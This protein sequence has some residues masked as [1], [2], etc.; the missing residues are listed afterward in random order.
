MSESII[1]K[2]I[3]RYIL[4]LL[5]DTNMIFYTI[6]WTHSV[7]QT[8]LSIGVKLI[9]KMDMHANGIYTAQ[10]I[11]HAYCHFLPI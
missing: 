4:I 7:V 3:L 9:I 11:G 10:I 5:C 1:S 8:N 2:N 6:E